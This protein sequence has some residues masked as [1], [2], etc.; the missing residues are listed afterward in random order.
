MVSIKLFAVV[1]ICIGLINS[2]ISNDPFFHSSGT[3]AR[4]NFYF[5]QQDNP[6]QTP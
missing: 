5:P 6:G 1:I 3:S 2:Q 4:Q